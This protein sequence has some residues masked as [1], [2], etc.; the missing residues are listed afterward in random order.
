VPLRLSVKPHERLIIGGA[1]VRNGDTRAELLI[2][3]EV[4]VL[5]ES[6]ILSPSAVRTPCERI[7]LA[8]QLMYVDA[9][10]LDRHLKT[11]RGLTADVR[12]AAPSLHGPLTVVDECVHQGR[13]YHALKSAR[14]LI[15]HERGLMPN[16]Q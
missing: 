13:Y 7:Y 11:Y 16:V 6:D 4:P 10:H 2:D 5:R 9:E 15:D 1:A 3:N 8:I 14:A 12:A